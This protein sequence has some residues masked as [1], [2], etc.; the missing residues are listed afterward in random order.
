MEKKT[1]LV[2]WVSGFLL[3]SLYV[4]L[5]PR[6]FD[7]G[8]V[9][10][11]FAYWSG[12]FLLASLL[13]RYVLGLDGLKSLGLQLHKGWWLNLSI[14]FLVG[15]STYGIK[16]LTFYE[17]SK[18]EIAGLMEVSFIWPMLG[19]AFLAMFFSSI[20]NDVTIRGYWYTFFRSRQQLVWYVFVA[21]LL[22]AF[23]DFWN[24]GVGLLNLA[25]SAVLGLTFAY[26]V[27]KTGSIW[28]SL[29]LHWGG[30]VMFRVLFGFTGQGIF[31]LEQ[32]QEGPLYDYISLLVTLLMLPIVYLILKG[33]GTPVSKPHLQQHEQVV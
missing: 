7:A 22:Y 9:P 1:P 13:S 33:R 11:W 30:N 24:E 29:G 10:M 19:Q 23:D 8:N 21:T 25:F 26:T 4:N 20:L 5:I 31:K 18:F 32:V 14:G 15:F 27:L 16:Y 28:M 3:L 12:F 6:F 2:L 17:L